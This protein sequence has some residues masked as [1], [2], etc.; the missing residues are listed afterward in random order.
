MS[1][2]EFPGWKTILPR[3]PCGPACRQAWKLAAESGAKEYTHVRL[4]MY[5]DGGIGRF[6]LF[7]RAVPPSTRSDE[8]IDLAAA[9]NGGVATDASDA[10]FSPP[11]NLLLPGRGVDMSDGWETKRS[12]A[13]GHR[14]WVVVR[15]GGG[16]G[17]VGKVHVDTAFYRGNYPVSCYVELWEEEE[18][19]EGREWVRYGQEVT[20]EA[21]KVHEITDAEGAWKAK[22]AEWVRLTIV[23][24]G[25][26]KRLRVWGTKGG[27]KDGE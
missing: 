26:V 11:G 16:G 9:A 27:G 14:D 3:V 24:D 25:G 1:G 8:V 5:P 10:Y 4:C 7:G 17:V 23:P 15:L 6:R 22:K 21:D 2:S 18:E 19:E 12:R 13:A 20:C